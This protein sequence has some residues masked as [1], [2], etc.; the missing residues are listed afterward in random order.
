MGDNSIEFSD[1]VWV[2][3]F[4]QDSLKKF[5][6]DVDKILSLNKN[7]STIRIFIDSLGGEVY[8][9]LGMIDYIQS[10]KFKNI[11]I[12]TVGIGKCMSSGL[13]LLASG[14]IG[15]R[16]ISPNT[17]LLLH[18]ISANVGG[19]FSELISS[20]ANISNLRNKVYRNLA[21]H[22]EH[23]NQ[24]FFLNIMEKENYTD[25][26]LEPKVAIRFKLADEIGLP[27]D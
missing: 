23:K 14:D 21:K 22:C 3:S 15:Y 24:D 19:K 17:T 20:S 10:P 4:T 16:F 26:Y 9:L 25:I 8:S 7:A 11:I 5:I 18:D 1:R 12:S 2:N 27:N 13:T 6:Y